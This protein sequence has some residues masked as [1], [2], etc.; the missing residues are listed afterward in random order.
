MY[1]RRKKEKI[2]QI[3]TTHGTI[4]KIRQYFYIVKHT[5]IHT[6]IHKQNSNQKFQKYYLCKF[7]HWK[8]S[9]SEEKKTF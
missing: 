1:E 2:H 5:H 4:P 7:K 8:F 3:N 6:Y 9:K